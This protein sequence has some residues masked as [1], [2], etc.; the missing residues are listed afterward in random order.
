[1]GQPGGK[2]GAG[3]FPKAQFDLETIGGAGDFAV[4]KIET[5]NYRL[6]KMEFVIRNLEIHNVNEDGQ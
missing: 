1:V 4:L 3:N 2:S 6:I 5:G